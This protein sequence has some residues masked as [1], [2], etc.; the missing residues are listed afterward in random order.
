LFALDTIGVDI[1][2]NHGKMFPN[3]AR[4]LL[5]ERLHMTIGLTTKGAQSAPLIGAAVIFVSLGA[6]LMSSRANEPNKDDDERSSGTAAARALLQS[7]E[8]AKRTQ[9]QLPFDSSERM[10]WNYV[11]TK[12]AGVALADLDANQKTL[13]DPLL[14]SALSPAGFKTAQQIVQHES[15]LGE[16]EGNPRRDPE[17]YYTVVFGE[18]GPRAPWAWRFEGHHLSV[19]ATHVGGQTQVVAPLFMGSNPERVPHGPKAGL[20]LLAAEEDLARELVR[21]LP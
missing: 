12:R 7:L 8:Q 21:M 19:N 11:P 9:A 15:I 1:V 16:I 10:N 20:R 6:A 2:A 3:L 14:R 5:H 17:L 13:I 18:P 4:N